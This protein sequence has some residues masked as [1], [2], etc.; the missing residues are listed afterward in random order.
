MW[1]LHQVSVHICAIVVAQFQLP[2]LARHLLT[3]PKTNP[4]LLPQLVDVDV[5]VLLCPL[6]N[7]MTAEQMS[8]LESGVGVF[9]LVPGEEFEERK[10][11]RAVVEL[12]W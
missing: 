6:Q 1:K 9:G 2:F 3:T 5:R 10:T 11:T 4:C 7:Q 8:M 12:L